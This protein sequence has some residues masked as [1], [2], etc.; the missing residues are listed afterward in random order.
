[1]GGPNIISTGSTN[2]ARIYGSYQGLGG[3]TMGSVISAGAIVSG[4]ETAKVAALPNYSTAALGSGLGGSFWESVSA[5]VSQDLIIMSYQV[6][7][8][9]AAYQGRTLV[10]RGIYLA[11]YVQTVI[12]GGPYVGEW[13]LAFGHTAVSL[14]TAEAAGTKAPRRIT[15]P[16]LQ[17]VTA[18][19]A[20]STAV[21][22]NQTFVDFGDAPVFINPGEFVQLCTRH[23]GTVCTGGTIVHKINPIYGW[24]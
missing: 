11:S 2:G 5:A 21:A 17:T 4:V 13:F 1:V 7:A 19:Q 22:Q 16:F 15:L 8:G 23:M 6:P 18:N 10:V 14:A 12:A 3:G 9:T 20:V 24:E